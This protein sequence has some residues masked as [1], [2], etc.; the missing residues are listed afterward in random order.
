MTLG[1]RLARLAAAVSAV[2]L[3]AAIGPA[4]AQQAGGGGLTVEQSAPR[5]APSP[6]PA[7]PAA[8]GAPQG[9]ST[10]RPQG[11][12]L[13]GVQLSRELGPDD[14]ALRYYMAMKQMDRVDAELQRLKRLY[15]DWQPPENLFEALHLTVEDEQPLWD[16]F[17]SN[18]ME[19]LEAAINERKR[20][21]PGWSPSSDL[22]RKIERRQVRAKLMDLFRRGMLAELIGLFAESEVDETDVEMIWVVAEAYARQKNTREA[23]ATY[24]IILRTSRESEQRIATIQKAMSTLRMVDVEQL[25]AMGKVDAAGRNEFHPIQTDIT[26]QRISAFLHDER[27][28]RIPEAEMKAFEEFARGAEDP[29]QPGLVGWYYYKIKVF[30]DSLEWF[31]LALQKGGDA[32]I[33]HGLAHSLRELGLYRETEEVAYAWRD[34]LVNNAILFIDILERDL[35]RQIPPWIEP[36]RLHR[37]AQ[38]TLDMGSGEGAQGLAWYAY[39]SCQFQTAY[40]WFQRAVA[41]SPKEAT[42]YGLAL[43]ARRLKLGK[44]FVALT[45]RYDGLFPMV[46]QLVFPDDEIRPPTPCDLLNASEKERQRLLAQQWNQPGPFGQQLAMPQPQQAGYGSMRR[47]IQPGDLQSA[48]G[49][50]PGQFGQFGQPPFAPQQGVAGFQAGYNPFSQQQQQPLKINRAEFPIPVDPENPLRFQASGKLQGRPAVVQVNAAMLPG[51][52]ASEPWQGTPPLVA[53]RVPGVGPM[54]YERYG[55][56]LLP[57]WTGI[58]EASPPHNAEYAPAGTIWTTQQATDAQATRGSNQGTDMMRMGIAAT[59]QQLAGIPRVPPPSA[60]RMGGHAAGELYRAPSAEGRE[61]AG[62]RP[63]LMVPQGIVPAGPMRRR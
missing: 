31:K 22:A 33:A 48:V 63:G 62:A 45:N 41:W 7:A 32:M 1:H 21:E 25:I 51:P 8:A 19:E 44:E 13:S 35:T 16:L 2:A 59:L 61:A 24:A 50:Q 38:V 29:N 42:V 14:S 20:T 3:S 52:F 11:F 9:V 39:N 40:E 5:A 27:P 36:E 26:R 47:G 55:F 54:P 43:T 12:A 46:V 4:L 18:S 57:G 56:L 49:G 17:A 37:Y 6:L 58:M 34:P 15:P 28:E 53:R 30:R 60:L 23:V 10:G